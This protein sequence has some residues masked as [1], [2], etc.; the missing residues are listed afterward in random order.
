MHAGEISNADILFV[1]KML[2]SELVD[3]KEQ[4]A[5]THELHGGVCRRRVR[6][7][8]GAGGGAGGGGGQKQDE[9]GE[10]GL[11]G[12]EESAQREPPSDKIDS[13]AALVELALARLDEVLEASD[14]IKDALSPRACATDGGGVGGVGLIPE[15]QEREK[16]MQNRESSVASVGGKTCSMCEESKP[17]EAFS[18]RQ[19]AA[20]TEVGS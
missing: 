17:Q 18:Q 15:M 11:R 16:A 4:S 5:S 19:W 9:D 13:L 20:V 14:G 1:T 10:R 8:G 7:G 6:G 12:E 2:W 3:W